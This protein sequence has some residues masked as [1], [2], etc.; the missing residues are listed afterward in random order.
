[1][2]VLEAVNLWTDLQE[3]DLIW[4]IDDTADY[5]ASASTVVG[6]AFSGA[7]VAYQSLLADLGPDW[8]K[9]LR[10]EVR[11]SDEGGEVYGSDFD[12]NIIGTGS[13]IAYAGDGDDVV[14]G[15]EGEDFIKGENDNDNLFGEGQR[16]AIFGDGGRDN[17]FG[18]AGNDELRG[19]E[20]QDV[21]KGEGDND[22]LFGENGDDRLYG[23]QGADWLNGGAGRD[24]LYGGSGADTFSFGIEDLAEAKFDIVDAIIDFGRG[25]TPTFSQSEGDQID[26][27]ELLS[28]AYLAGEAIGDLVRFERSQIDN[29]LRLLID[30]DGIG[31]QEDWVT[32][33]V[34]QDVPAGAAIDPIVVQGSTGVGL[35]G[36]VPSSPGS[37]AISSVSQNV[38]EGSSTIEFTITR[39]DDT[40]S[41]TVFVSTTV[42]RGSANNSDYEFLLNEPLVFAAGV[43]TATV[44]VDILEDGSDESLETFGLIIQSSP[45]QPA[46]QF[47]ASASFTI[48]DDDAAGST[49]NFTENNDNEWIE[50][51]GGA[52]F[53]NGL[54]GT[55]TATL[56]LRDWTAGINT[57]TSSGNRTFSSGSDS[58]VFTELEN[59]FVIGGSGNDRITTGSGNDGILGLGGDDTIDGGVGID[60]MDGGDGDD[61]FLNV[62]FGEVI[63]GGQGADLVNFNV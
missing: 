5:F 49:V 52:E 11:A 46:S 47:L 21:L 4:D 8:A 7:S 37:Y 12:D 55:D 50:P 62:G 9:G 36:G 51:S 60:V 45:D 57:T 40:L 10:I 44:T 30:V 63:A 18:G 42:N 24:E 19:G 14:Y 25:N 43:D 56:D 34:L 13:D 28:G 22:V 6:E 48:I 20:G 58:V 15:G 53:F 1:N 33:A 59:F 38:I 41:E 29:Q 23:D 61:A 26:L 3:A 35:G 17:L 32:I 31:V 39:P 2:A 16:D 54:G 27:S